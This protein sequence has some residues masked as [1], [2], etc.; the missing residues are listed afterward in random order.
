MKSQR[1][2]FGGC[3]DACGRPVVG[4]WLLSAAGMH[5]A[6][7]VCEGCRDSPEFSTWPGATFKAATSEGTN[8]N[9]YWV[10]CECGCGH[11]AGARIEDMDRT[12]R[13]LRCPTCVAGGHPAAERSAESFAADQRVRRLL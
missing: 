2:R 3:L 8:G 10:A 9:G 5:Y 4:Y 1:I 6:P 7:E 13:H 11:V 12:G